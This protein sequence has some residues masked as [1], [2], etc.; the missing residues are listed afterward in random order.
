MLLQRDGSAPIEYKFHVSCGRTSYVYLKF[1]CQH[2]QT[3]ECALDRDGQVFDLDPAAVE[4]TAHIL[5]P[6]GFEQLRATAERLAEPFDF[7][8]CDLYDLDGDIYFS[9]LTVYPLGGFSQVNNDHIA[10]LRNAMW[11]IRESW[12]LTNAQSGWLRVY[13]RALRQWLDH[14]TDQTG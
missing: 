2:G 11:D 7:I 13:A 8:R 10:G 1:Q 6:K 9:E 3:T 12:F 14:S 5:P 4:Q